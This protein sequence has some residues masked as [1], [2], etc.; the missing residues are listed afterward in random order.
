MED[1]RADNMNELVVSVVIPFYNVGKYA[2]GT[3]ESLLEQDYRNCE[4]VCVDDGSTDNTLAILNEYIKDERVKIYHK[5]NGGLSD[6]RNY[7]IS[8]AVGDYI[9]LI[10]GDDY[11]HPQY[12]TQLVKATGGK[13]DCLVIGKLQVV[14]YKEQLDVKE[15]WANYI[16]SYSLKKRDVF[17]KILYNEL[18]VSA[19]AKLIPKSAYDDIKFPLGKVS[20][21]VATIGELVKK[22]NDFFVVE[23][24][25]YAYVMRADSIGH[26]K[27]LYYKEIKDRFDALKSFET[28]IKNEYD[29]SKEKSINVALKYRWGYRLVDMATMYDKVVDDKNAALLAKKNAKSWLRKNIGAIMV[30][31]RAPLK[32][33]LRMWLYAYFPEVYILMYSLFQKMKYN[34]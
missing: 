17:E 12:I 19:C 32:Q 26:K 31:K 18:S 9:T 8:V 7:G 33:R 15:G 28:V 30:N 2:R 23:Q 13:K 6:A 34:V 24:P 29:L 20:E 16:T 21:E 25:L 22:F 3:M 4:F 11:V 14:K 10:D 27:E 1:N 5:E